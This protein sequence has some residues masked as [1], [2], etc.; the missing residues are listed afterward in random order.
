VEHEP[1]GLHYFE[2]NTSLPF[3]VTMVPCST[4]LDHVFRFHITVQALVENPKKWWWKN[5]FEH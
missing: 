2:C 3:F 5:C 1:T 4:F